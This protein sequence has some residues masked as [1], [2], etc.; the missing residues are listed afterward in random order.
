MSEAFREKVEPAVEPEAKGTT[1]T[2]AS[3]SKVEVPY[4]DYEQENGKP[5]L[6]EIFELGEHWADRVGGFNEEIQAIEDYLREQVTS[7]EID[8][9]LK[10]VKNRIK[11]I[12]KVV[13]VDK[14]DRAV[15]KLEVMAEYVKFLMKKE[16]NQFRRFRISA[17]TRSLIFQL[18]RTWYITQ[19][20]LL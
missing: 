8:N 20:L 10:G 7:R 18:L 11:E 4:L 3:V 13:G 15:I 6:V 14:E 5:Y 12:E 9:S 19:H 16:L 1:P 17:L 2:Q